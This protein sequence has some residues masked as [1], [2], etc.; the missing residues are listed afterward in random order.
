ML[1]IPDANELQALRKGL[2]RRKL[3]PIAVGMKGG[4]RGSGYFEVRGLA[5]DFTV[6]WNLEG[7]SAKEAHFRAMCTQPELEH[8]RLELGL[9]VCEIASVEA[10]RIM[11]SIGHPIEAFRQSDG[12]RQVAAAWR[13]WALVPPGHMLGLAPRA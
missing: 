2:R 13:H 8:Q 9:L 1:S 10:Q 12:I 3:P 11:D 7:G 5:G 6:H 4:A